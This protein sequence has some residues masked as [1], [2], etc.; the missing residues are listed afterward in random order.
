MV[1]TLPYL[2]NL[3]KVTIKS[4][5]S[6]TMV[7]NKIVIDE[8]VLPHFK[9]HTHAPSIETLSVN[10]NSVSFLYNTTTKCD[11]EE[12]KIWLVILGFNIRER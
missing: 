3:G 7:V 10:I 5:A 11:A 6:T 1:F 9:F 8:V 12:E 4:S 2:P